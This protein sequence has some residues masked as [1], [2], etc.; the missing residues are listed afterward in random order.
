MSEGGVQR[1]IFKLYFKYLVLSNVHL[2]K[3][4]PDVILKIFTMLRAKES[5]NRNCRQTLQNVNNTHTHYILYIFSVYGN[6]IYLNI[7]ILIRLNPSFSICCPLPSLWSATSQICSHEAHF[8]CLGHSSQPLHKNSDKALI[9]SFVLEN[10]LL[11]KWW[12]DFRKRYSLI[13]EMSAI[14][15]YPPSGRMGCSPTLSRHVA[16]FLRLWCNLSG[17]CWK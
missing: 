7:I 13:E 5:W 17:S 16:S 2:D 9:G 4:K 1:E 11:G 3:A 14:M 6:Y 8:E 15:K 12:V 10:N